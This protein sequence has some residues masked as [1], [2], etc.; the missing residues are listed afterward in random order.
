MSRNW[1]LIAQGVAPEIPEPELDRAVAVL[2]AL[3]EQFAPLLERLPH[4]TEPAL[5]F[6]P[7]SH[8]PEELA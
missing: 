5:V 2:Q 1:K 6:L 4:D 8:G 7:K 3:V